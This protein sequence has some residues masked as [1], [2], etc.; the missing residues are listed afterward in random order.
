MGTTANIDTARDRIERS[1]L[2]R[3]PRSRVWRAL[4]SAKEFGA[5]FRVELQGDF[6][7]GERISGKVTYP[8]HEGTPF[9]AQVER[10]EPERL[11]SFRWPMGSDPEALELRNHTTLVEFELEDAPQGTVLTVVESGFEGLPAPRRLEAYRENSEGWAIQ[12]ENVR[13]HAEG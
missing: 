3:A 9:V 13:R 5:W 6:T 8:G 4:T 12:M 10:M 7:A 2:I 1:I 11:F